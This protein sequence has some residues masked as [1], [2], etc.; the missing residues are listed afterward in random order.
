[1]LFIQHP[2]S[3]LSPPPPP[4]PTHAHNCLL[5]FSFQARNLRLLERPDLGS[6]R[7]ACCYVD[8]MLAQDKP[9]GRTL[10]HIA[11]NPPSPPPLPFSPPP[12]HPQTQA[13][14]LRLLERPDLGSCRVLVADS[15]SNSVAPGVEV[16]TGQAAIYH[17][18]RFS[19][20]RVCTLHFVNGCLRDGG[21][22]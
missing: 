18:P 11:L 17:M 2:P 21:A 22:P 10:S 15:S 19:E 6:C 20:V 9:H 14:N 7:V 12:P 13:R 16:P 4:P 8:T 3:C 5:L 1:M